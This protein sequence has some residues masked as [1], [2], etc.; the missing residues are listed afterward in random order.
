MKKEIGITKEKA[1]YEKL[2]IGKQANEVCLI[3]DR[4]VMGSVTSLEG[5]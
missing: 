4:T 2:K 3:R 1:P 5:N